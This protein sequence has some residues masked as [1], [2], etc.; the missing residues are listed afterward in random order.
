[1]S[2][3]NKPLNFF[4]EQLKDI[5]IKL[6]Y[7]QPELA[8]ILNVKRQTISSWE[9]GLTSPDVAKL[10]ALKEHAAS[11]GLNVD[12][13]D[14]FGDTK[15]DT[16]ETPLSYLI[17]FFKQLDDMG[18]R[19]IYH[20]RGE[21]LESFRLALEREHDSITVVSSS[22]TGVLRVASAKISELL[23]RKSKE[24]RS[25]RILMTEP[26]TMGS[27][28]EKQEGR[29]K[30]SIA[31]EINENVA[32]LIENWELN[33][34]NIRFY[35]GAPTVF[36]LFTSER[37]LLNPYSYQTEAFKTFTLEVAKTAY[38]DDIYSQYYDNH[39]YRSWIGSNSISYD[40]YLEDK[41]EK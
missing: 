15:L 38:L 34:E 24:V 26:E 36:L 40:E 16:G 2:N 1:M 14:L 3:S 13:A 12:L 17:K 33:T 22:F 29:A 28:R 10:F 23:N 4:G 8:N 35:K 30:G 7:T 5:R 11:V 39:F 9:Q 6:S 31:E 32:R 21:A 25:F 19:G 37:M 20:S 18:L 41:K 27:L